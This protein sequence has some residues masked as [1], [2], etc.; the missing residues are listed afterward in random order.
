VRYGITPPIS[1]QEPAE[2][3]LVLSRKM[4]EE[5]EAEF[6]KETA[7]GMARREAVLKELER[8][9]TE[10]STE[11]GVATGMSEEE[12]KSA[13][14][15][16]VTLGSYRLG[17]V[18]ADSAIDA[19]C[20]G[21]P[22]VNHEAFSTTLASKLQQRESVSQCVPL[23]DANTPLIKLTMRGVN[24]DLCFARL[25]KPLAFGQS[26]EDMVKDDKVLRDMDDKSVRSVNGYRVAEQILELVPDREAFRQTL[27]FVKFWAIRRGIY[28]S[29]FG[30][31]GGVT[32]A[33]LVARVCQLY[34]H[35]S[36]SQL[37]NRFF[38]VYDQWNWSKPVMLCEIVELQAVPG[39]SGFKVWNPKSNPGDRQ[40]IMP[41]I[42]PAFPAMN[43]TENVTETTKR[44]LLDEFRR[45]YEVVKNVEAN[46]ASWKAVHDPFPFFSQFRHFLW[47][48]VLGK[49]DEA[50]QKYSG[51]IES[52]LRILTKQ[53]EGTPGMIIHP[54]PKQYDLRGKDSD[55]PRGC[56]M[57][58]AM[59]FFADQGAFAGQTVDLRP[60]LAQF[61]D[62]ANQWPEKDAYSG[63]HML[64]LRQV[65]RFRLPEYVLDE[66]NRREVPSPKKARQS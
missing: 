43:S 14:V 59:A 66:T 63:Q 60:A 11:V 56:G 13:S 8:A 21:P 44:I 23:P 18:H 16:V 20:I 17:V 46:K 22:H 55:W 7:E 61:V 36:P 3:D 58:I 53:L 6:P 65:K 9:V 33:V 2:T 57:F 42:T 1:L 34:P 37:V 50:Y 40:H 27:R 62:V 29:V 4:M 35:Y 39:M 30:L 38:R 5:L 45:G 47:L 25:V 41:V 24:V 48:E 51:W 32:W 54:N 64:R 12:A 31:F 15:K 26:P 19:L 28:R 10:W 52:K 49:T